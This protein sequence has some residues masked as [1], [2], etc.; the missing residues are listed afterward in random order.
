MLSVF[1]FKIVEI[2]NLAL[3][4]TVVSHSQ[5]LKRN[6]KIFTAFIVHVPLFLCMG[7]W[8]LYAVKPV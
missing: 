4:I 1:R 6:S 2:G 5:V 8:K 7:K 3:V